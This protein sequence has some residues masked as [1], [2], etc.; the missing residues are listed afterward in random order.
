MSE[1]RGKIELETGLVGEHFHDP[2]RSRIAAAGAGLIVIGIE[3]ESVIETGGCSF[4][5]FSYGCRVPEIEAGFMNVSKLA[6]G[7]QCG[8]DRKKFI[9]TDLQFVLKDG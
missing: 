2:A 1:W 7:D 9:R 4:E 6:S 5:V 3:N 8:I